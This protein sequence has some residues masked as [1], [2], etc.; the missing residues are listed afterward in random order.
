MT[1]EYSEK[2]QLAPPLMAR[3]VLF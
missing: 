3:K 2:I 1:S